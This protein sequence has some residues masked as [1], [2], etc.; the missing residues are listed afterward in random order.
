M[1]REP[2][3]KCQ[4]LVGEPLDGVGGVVLEAAQVNDQMDGV[5][6]GPD[7]GPAVDPRLENDQVR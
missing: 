1:F 2:G 5:L 7:V 6:V 4:E 3:K